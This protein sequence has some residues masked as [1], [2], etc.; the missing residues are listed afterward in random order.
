MY[1]KVERSDYV[2]VDDMDL[3]DIKHR[4]QTIEATQKL[5]AEV[6]LDIAKALMRIDARVKQLDDQ[7]RIIRRLDT[8]W[9]SIASSTE[10]SVGFM[11]AVKDYMGLDYEMDE[12]VKDRLQG[13]EE[14]QTIIAAEL[15]VVVA[16]L[17]VSDGLLR[18]IHAKVG[19]DYDGRIDA[20]L[21]EIA[22]NC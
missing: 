8:A 21:D 2:D 16:A 11:E 9:R 17:R 7:S 1:G 4:L 15:A 13:I 12:D 5:N 18:S 14:K 20:L 22:D 6:S 19:A 10:A 3:R